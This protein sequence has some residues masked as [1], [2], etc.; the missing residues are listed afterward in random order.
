MLE[1]MIS[2]TLLTALVIV[3]RFF[4]KGR[5]SPRL[6]YALWALVLVRLL[7]PVSFG[8]TEISV[9]NLTQRAAATETAQVVST[10]TQ[11]ELP[12][13][14]YDAAYSEVKQEYAEKGIDIAQLPT[15]QLEQV[16]Y[17]VL[18]RMGATWSVRDIL[19]GLWLCG[20]AVSSLFLFGSN[21]RFAAQLRKTRR[22]MEVQ[23]CPLPVYVSSG[24]DTPCLF[25][26]F[27]PAIY[28][29][30]ETLANATILRHSIQHELTHYRHGDH[31][32]SLL[33]GVCLAVHWFNPLVWWAAAL[34]R[35]DSDLACDEATIRRL[36]E[37]ER[38]E[39]GRT[40]IQMTCG[41]RP[42]L[43][44]TATTMSGSGSSIRER[45]VTIARKP[46]TAAF[47]LMLVILVASLAVGCTFTG[48]K[49]PAVE[50]NPENNRIETSDTLEPVETMETAPASGGDLEPEIPEV[51]TPKAAMEQLLASGD[52]TLELGVIDEGN[53]R[54]YPAY[55]M[56]DWFYDSLRAKVN[57]YTWTELDTPL[58]EDSGYWVTVFSGDKTRI[59]TFN[60]GGLVCYQSEETSIWWQTEPIGMY[61]MPLAEELRR[62][63]DNLEASY[64]R[65]VF[66][67]DGTAEEAADFFVHTAY[68]FRMMNLAP[69]S[70]YGILDYEVVDWNVMEVSESG[71]AVVGR[72]ECAFTPCD[73][74]SPN[75]WAGNTGEGT[76][77]F[78]GKLTYSREFVLQLQ[79]DG[80]W[81]CIELGT[82]GCRLPK[83]T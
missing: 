51:L 75:I 44:L 47:T 37:G 52:A 39:Y 56:E 34:S 26:L 23:S 11:M 74:M 21:A 53:A 24:L 5:V 67:M 77:K 70:S 46:K 55:P 78:E 1:W 42:T 15:E 30:P 17:E 69:G 71:D 64:T 40:L 9:E 31:V 25:G 41:Q 16:D 61:T 54:T 82:G 76:G 57:N 62:E 18:A 83:N 36:G 7:I 6:Q 35:N 72:F 60:A 10:F 81:H 79:E 8:S 27:R 20:V 2:S 66:A 63:Y 43:L 19:M 68:G 80:L 32:W 22:R 38:A 49:A 14:T 29:T 3:L 50:Q 4:L 65:I 48:A 13:K 28:V 45:I 59:M 33:R 12:A 58:P 73:P